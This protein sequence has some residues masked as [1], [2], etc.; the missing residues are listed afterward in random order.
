M[1]TVRI[2]ED[3]WDAIAAK[4][5]FGETVDD[6]LRRELGIKIKN[7]PAPQARQRLATNRMTTRI[8]GNVLLVEFADGASQQW[9]LPMKSEREA[10]RRVRREALDFAKSHDANTWTVQC[11]DK[12]TTDAGITLQSRANSCSILEIKLSA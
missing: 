3:V 12:T 11:R 9:K 4:G 10:I 1:K 2:S 8:E 5:K 6:V 7:A